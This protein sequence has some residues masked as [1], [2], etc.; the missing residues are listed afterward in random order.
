[1]C[2]SCQPVNH[3]H[4]PHPFLQD[5]EHEC[6]LPCGKKLQCGLHHCQ[7]SCHR[8]HCQ[9]CWENSES[10]NMSIVSLLLKFIYSQ[11]ASHS[12]IVSLLLKCIYSQLASH[13]VIDTISQHISCLEHTGYTVGCTIRKTSF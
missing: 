13:S 6:E 11:L 12:V 8:G 5:T 9:Q 1:M 7:E 4:F 10:L 3:I 2:S